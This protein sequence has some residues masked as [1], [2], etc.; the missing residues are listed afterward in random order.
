M[1][2]IGSKK[3]DVINLGYD[4]IRFQCTTDGLLFSFRAK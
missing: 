3:E 2:L 4:Q 1:I